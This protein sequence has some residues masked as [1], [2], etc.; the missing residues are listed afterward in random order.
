MDKS[1]RQILDEQGT[2][3]F[4]TTI[5]RAVDALTPAFRC[6]TTRERGLTSWPITQEDDVRDLLF[7]MLRASI[8]DIR[9]EEPTPSRAGSSRVA[10]LRSRLARTLIEIKW[11]RKGRWR[12]VL[13]EIYAD[14]Q[15][16]GRHPDCRYLTFVIIDAARDISDPH[17][18]EIELNGDQIIDGKNIRITAYKRQL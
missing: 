2:A 12:R 16:Y 5:R 7:V 14:I 9:R 3:A 1:R 13:D 6:F 4:L 15:T 8:D 11:V 17:L 10:D 18:V